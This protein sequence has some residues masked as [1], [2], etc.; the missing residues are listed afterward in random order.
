MDQK[1][2]YHLSIRLYGEDKAFGPGV[3]QLLRGIEA[4]GSL[5]GAA[6]SMNMAYSKAWKVMKNAERELGFALT[7][8]E[9]GGKDGGGSRLTPQARVLLAR[10]DAFSGKIRQAADEAFAEYF[11]PGWM[12]EE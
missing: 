6:Q 4:C 5:Q 1:L 7:D 8:R 2:R 9:S 3:A 10:Y 12:E 11:A